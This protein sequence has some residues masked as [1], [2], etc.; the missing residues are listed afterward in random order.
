MKTVDLAI[1]GAGPAGMAAAVLAAELGLDT[2]L[3]DEQPAPGGQIYR[4]FERACPDS[5]LGPDYL[6][7]AGLV[8]ALC[9]SAVDYRPAATVWRLDPEGRVDLAADGRLDTIKARRILLATGAIE[10]PVPTA[11]WTLPGVMTLGAARI[12]LKTADLVPAG[13]TVLAGQ[14]PLLPLVAA[15]LARAGAPP[16]AILATTPASNYRAAA[17]ILGR[18]WPGL[19]PLLKGA[20]SLLSVR[21]AGIPIRRGV[22]GLRAIG[23]G[24]LERVA[25]EGGETAADHLFV[26]EG[27]IPNIQI[28]LALQLRHEWSRDQLCWRPALDSWGQTSL[29]CVAVAG[30]AGGIAGAAA[31]RLTGQLA[32]L[33]SAA[34]LGR[35]GAPERDRRAAP[36]RAALVR[37]RAMR[38]FLDRLYRPPH[39]V[40]VPVDDTTIVCRCEEIS[41]A[42]IRTAVRHGAVGPNQLQACTRCG[43]GPCQGRICGAPVA[44]IIADTLGRPIGEIGP[45]QPRAPDKPITLGALAD[46]EA[47]AAP[48]GAAEI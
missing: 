47:A 39:A 12:L 10:R 46:I 25:W 42:Q 28:G 24:E 20:R 6:E 5:A 37:E 41:V 21:I 2:M 38:A 1:V 33:D 14:G 27:T 16:V 3:I 15:Q 34:L 44:A 22:R 19:Q 9:A 29:A 8:A 17:R 48:R 4:G 43:M 32:A 30:D 31:A 23:E 40:L 13:R 35:I 18:R 26:H 36:V 11:G 7:G 45:W